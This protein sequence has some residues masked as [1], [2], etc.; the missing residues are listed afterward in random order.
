MPPPTAPEAAPSGTAEASKPP[1][2]A[3]EMPKSSGQTPVLKSDPQEIT[4]SFGSPPA[5]LEL[6]ET[7]R[8]TLKI[9][10]NAFTSA[11]NLTFKIDKKGKSNGPPIG[12]IYR[13]T[14]V[15]PPE[16][17]PARVDSAVGA[18]ELTM[19]AGDRKDA[20]LALGEV[21]TD[22]NGKQKIT[23]TVVAPVKIDDATAT[24]RFELKTLSDAYLHITTKAVT[25]PAP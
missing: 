22:E 16:G 19:P 5:K 20:N 23:W 14:P 11:V 8:V 10:E 13:L 6:G 18:F 21:T 25:A 4:D 24:A 7:E 1:K 12:K 2:A 15:I 17:E 3:P 9:P